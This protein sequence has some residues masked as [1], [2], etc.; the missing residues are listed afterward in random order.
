MHRSLLFCPGSRPDLMEKAERSGAD[1]LIFDLEDS[2]ASTAK[3]DA[4]SNVHS[5]LQRASDVPVYVRISHPSAGNGAA[6]LDALAGHRLEGVVLPKAEHASDIQALDQALQQVETKLGLPEETLAI[7][8]MIETCLGLH[9]AFNIITASKRVRGIALASAEEGDLM[10]D[11][12]GRWTPEGEAMLYPRGRLVCEARAAGVEWLIDG[13]FMN[14]RD[15]AALRREC[16]MARNMGYVSKMAIHPRQVEVFHQIFTPSD[17]ELEYAKGLV[18]A[19]RAA[20]QS[21]TSAIQ[22][23][24]MMVDYANMKHAERILARGKERIA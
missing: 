3:Q 24:G 12:G 7:V 16:Q 2:V 18:E 1:A 8:P 22:Y 23:R 19:F 17:E 14:L 9:H 15:E 4:R 11:L 20:E 21:G 5:A 10:V 13:V 6:D